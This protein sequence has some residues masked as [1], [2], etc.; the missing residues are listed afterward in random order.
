MK[1]RAWLGSRGPEYARERASSLINRYGLTSSAASARVEACVALLA[2]FGC[3]PTFPTPGRVVQRYP[4]F[5]RRIQEAGAEIAVHSYDHVDLKLYPLDSALEQLLKATRVFA[6]HGIEMRGFRCPYL[7]CSDELLDALPKGVFDYSSNRA[8]WWHLMPPADSG[9][10]TSSFDVLYRLYK[11]A[12]AA[13]KVCT[14]WTTSNVVEIPVSLPDDIQLHDGLCLDAEEMARAWDEI[15]HETHQRG[16][17]FVLQFHPELMWESKYA[18]ET[19]LKETE[20]LHPSVWVARLRDISSWWRE[21]SHFETIVSNSPTGL[22]ISFTSSERATILARGLEAC[23]SALPWEEPYRQLLVRELVVPPDPRPFVG[24]S[25]D[26]P[27]RVVRFLREQG[28][29]IDTSET[30]SLCSTY[31]DAALAETAT[32]VGL[33]EHIERSP[34][35]L[36][37]YWR[38]PNGAKSAMCF[39]GDLDALSLFDYLFR[40]FAR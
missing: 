18:F 40:L 27:P 38:W 19:L 32:E 31:V 26:A 9:R 16:E 36:I 1:L 7:S 21:K 30:A 4:E 8:I 17:L 35:P 14:P 28:Y 29:I 25:V 3:A 33:V 5:I 20:C 2:Q 39:T 6:H 10:A 37:R 15:L 34:G 24:L 23:N 12:S 13:D 22:H 11:P